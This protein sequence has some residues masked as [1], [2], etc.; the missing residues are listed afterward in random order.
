M[1]RCNEGE[2][3][4][5]VSVQVLHT[6]TLHLESRDVVAHV[7]GGPFRT[8]DGRVGNHIGRK[9]AP[10]H[11]LRSH[12]GK[13]RKR[14]RTPPPRLVL[15]A[16]HRRGRLLLLLQ[17]AFQGM[18]EEYQ[19]QSCQQQLPTCHHSC[20]EINARHKSDVSHRS[21]TVFSS[22]Y[23]IASFYHHLSSH[24][25]HYHYPTPNLKSIICSSSSS[26]HPLPVCLQNLPFL[27]FVTS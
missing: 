24:K 16:V 3:H 7:S 1:A 19:Q 17:L 25:P 10:Q 6:T 11:L 12:T 8:V 20:N 5:D 26:L 23:L 14:G 21:F 22:T 4:V 2:E 27:P 13:R 15:S 9:N 18:H